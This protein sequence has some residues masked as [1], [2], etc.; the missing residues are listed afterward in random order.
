[1]KRGIKKIPATMRE[2]VGG[3]QAS[4]ARRQGI[5]RVITVISSYSQRLD[6]RSSSIIKGKIRQKGDR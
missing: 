4:E 1:M 3:T 2:A 6:T 5:L